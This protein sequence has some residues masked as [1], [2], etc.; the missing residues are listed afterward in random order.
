MRLTIV[1]KVFNIEYQRTRFDLINPWVTI[2]GFT[3]LIN[4]SKF[5]PDDK[6]MSDILPLLEESNKYYIDTK[7]LTNSLHNLC[8]RLLKKHDLPNDILVYAK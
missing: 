7:S 5:H 2:C 6:K 8:Y 3:I 4:N 1:N